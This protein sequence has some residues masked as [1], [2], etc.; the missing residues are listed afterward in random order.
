VGRRPGSRIASNYSTEGAAGCLS[1]AASARMLLRAHS[2]CHLPAGVGAGFADR[3]T[4]I[5]SPD[6]LAVLGAFGADLSTL[7]AGVLVMRRVDQHEMGGG[8][9]YFRAGHH[10][11]EMGGFD[12][13]PACLQA[14]VHRRG[15]AGFVA[16][17]TGFDAAALERPALCRTFL[18]GA[19][20]LFR[21][22][23]TFRG[24]SAGRYLAAEV[25][26][27]PGGRMVF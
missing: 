1:F 11:A 15:Q 12:M 14:M 5:H 22:R 13:L 27:F 24:R 7:L 8:S 26:T 3:H 25:P 4:L 18:A 17:Q 21:R 16:A 2:S 10:E 6:A 23:R 9:A 20:R 19:G